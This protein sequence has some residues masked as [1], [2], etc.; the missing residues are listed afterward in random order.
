MKNGKFNV[1][2]A[3]YATKGEVFEHPFVAL[4]TCFWIILEHHPHFFRAA[5]WGLNSYTTNPIRRLWS[6]LGGLGLY[7][8]RRASKKVNV[9]GYDPP[10]FENTSWA[11]LILMSL[12]P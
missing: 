9:K 1:E 5:R 10:V 3:D 11:T 7:L 4:K 12:V 2:R 6:T 8:T